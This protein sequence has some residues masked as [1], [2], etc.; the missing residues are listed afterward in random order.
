MA[1]GRGGQEA[2]APCPL[3]QTLSP[4]PI[5]FLT[6]QGVSL[7]LTA[8]WGGWGGEFEERAGGPPTPRPS[9]QDPFR[10]SLI[11]SSKKFSTQKPRFPWNK[12]VRT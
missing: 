7:N 10:N 4:N 9:P 5:H 2:A 6:N 12:R 1:F 8:F 3:C 11:L